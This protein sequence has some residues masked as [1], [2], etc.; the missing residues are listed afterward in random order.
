MSPKKNHEGSMA[1]KG[2]LNVISSDFA[3]ERETGAAGR[4]M[5]LKFHE[6]LS[7]G[8]TVGKKRG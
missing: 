8:N 7:L 3:S 6:L 1:K 4:S 2:T 5:P